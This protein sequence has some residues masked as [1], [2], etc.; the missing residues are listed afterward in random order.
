MPY[1]HSKWV[2]FLSRAPGGKKKTKHCSLT[3]FSRRPF[4]ELS[5]PLGMSFRFFPRKKGP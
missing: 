1:D 5:Q 3:G 4:V 2:S